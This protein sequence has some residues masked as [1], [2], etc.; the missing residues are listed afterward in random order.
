MTTILSWNIQCGR[1]VD[2]EIDLSRTVDVIKGIAD[3]DVICLQEISRLDPELDGGQCVDQALI[4]ASLF[5][6]H[7]YVF[8]PALDRGRNGS[9]KRRQFGNMILT[10]FP[11]IQ[12]YN[13]MLP[14]PMPPAPCRHMPRQALEVVIE[15][16]DGPLRITTTH[17]EYHCNEQ[18]LAQVR[19]MCEIQCEVIANQSYP[20][21]APASGPYAA[22]SRP[23]RSILCGD[24]N[25]IPGDSVYK[26]ITQP[27]SEM[28]SGYLDAWRVI[29]GQTPHAPTCGIYDRKQWPQGPHCR[30]YF[31]ITSD[32]VELASDTQSF[33]ETNASDHQPVLLELRT[34]D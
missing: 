33:T 18:R 9:R 4:L 19:R 30:D 12:V 21:Y 34:Q 20:K 5:P 32:L 27:T 16:E 24:F 10:R 2:G 7:Q 14:Q 8:G 28:P 23:V 13:H 15:A 25:A 3:A 11:L 31:F 17:L 29:H 26:Y 22:V 6:D 1:G